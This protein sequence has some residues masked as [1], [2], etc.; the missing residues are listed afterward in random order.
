MTFSFALQ[1]YGCAL[2]YVLVMIDGTYDVTGSYGAYYLN[3]QYA[4]KVIDATVLSAWDAISF[5]Y[6][7]YSKEQHAATPVE[8]KHALMASI[9]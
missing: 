2:G 8:A 6:E 9:A 4:Q 7:T 1:H 3:G 5:E